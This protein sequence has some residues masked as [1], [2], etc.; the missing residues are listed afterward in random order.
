MHFGDRD[1]QLSC[2]KMVN[3]NNRLL[4]SAFEANLPGL[5]PMSPNKNPVV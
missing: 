3:C 4:I 2:L 1:G 5:Q